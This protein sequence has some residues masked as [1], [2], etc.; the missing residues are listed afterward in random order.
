LT[1]I[2]L[3]CIGCSDNANYLIKKGKVGKIHSKSIVKEIDSLFS[4]DSI[5]KR[6]GGGDYMFESEDKYLIYD[7]SNNHLLTLIPKQQHDRN[8][9]IETIQI[10]SNKF[11]TSKGININ[12]SF[13]DINNKHKISS[14]QNT[15]N[16]V[17]VFVDEIDAYFIIDKENFALELR[18]GTEKKI[19]SINIPSNSKIKR[20]MIGWN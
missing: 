5:V 20:F 19:E 4:N 12:S 13:G 8:E 14:I 2:I 9:K 3:S 1:I 10:F 16:N 6:I 7:N 15:I 17:V 11:Q 18:I